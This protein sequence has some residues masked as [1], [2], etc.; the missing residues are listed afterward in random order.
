[1]PLGSHHVAGVTPGGPTNKWQGLRAQ[2]PPTGLLASKWVLQRNL[3][4]VSYPVAMTGP[5]G[6]GIWGLGRR[7]A[8][9]EAEKDEKPASNA[10][11]LNLPGDSALGVEGTSGQTFPDLFPPLGRI[12]FG[13][14]RGRRGPLRCLLALP[15]LPCVRREGATV[16]AGKLLT[17]PSR[18]AF[19]TSRMRVKF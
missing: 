2:Q 9:L 14:L 4:T 3:S 8:S 1:M 11:S 13:P 7:V 6:F 10:A 5:A 15:F 19:R 16:R 12:P 18:D 17:A